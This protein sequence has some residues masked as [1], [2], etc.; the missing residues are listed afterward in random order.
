MII[1]AKQLNQII[2]GP[3]YDSAP[4]YLMLQAPIFLLAGLGYQVLNS[5]FNGANETKTTLKMCS[6][7]FL[8]FMLLSPPLTM[9]FSVSG[10]IIALI[11][12]NLAATL[13]GA[14]RAKTMFKVDYPCKTLLLIYGASAFSAVLAYLTLQI[15]PFPTIPNSPLPPQY[16]S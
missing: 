3:Q 4:T 15:T 5:L 14:Y 9:Q 10:L 8:I 12:S 6:I 11:T 2:Y 13:Y 1:F 16:T 7:T